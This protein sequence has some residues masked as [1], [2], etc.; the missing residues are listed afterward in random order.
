M[1]CVTDHA[2]SRATQRTQYAYAL[3][4]M[5]SFYCNLKKL[6]APW[7]LPGRFFI[8]SSWAIIQRFFIV[9]ILLFFSVSVVP[10][11]VSFSFQRL[12]LY[13]FRLSFLCGFRRRR[14]QRLWFPSRAWMRLRQEPFEHVSVTF[15]HPSLRS[16]SG[17]GNVSLSFPS[18][19]F[20]CSLLFLCCHST[21]CAQRWKL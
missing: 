7:T 8:V 13:R 12:F 11:N 5:S 18:S 19:H 4:A 17:R 10:G 1:C 20:H 21:T 9:S 2:C 15:P 16:P 14:K 3:F 6:S